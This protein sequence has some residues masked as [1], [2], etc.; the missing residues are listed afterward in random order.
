M[1]NKYGVEL[2]QGKKIIICKNNIFLIKIFKTKNKEIL[3]NRYVW[4]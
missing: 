1:E 2:N 3:M 4:I